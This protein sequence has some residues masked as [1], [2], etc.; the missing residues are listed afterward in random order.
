M[1]PFLLTPKSL[2]NAQLKRPEGLHRVHHSM[3]G[4]VDWAMARWSARVFRPRCR[5]ARRTQRGW[6][7][8]GFWRIMDIRLLTLYWFITILAT[9]LAVAPQRCKYTFWL[10]RGYL[11]L[12]RETTQAHGAEASR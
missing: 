11:R 4:M 1:Q 9:N 5:G 7:S 8:T 2:G 10:L 3:Y 6:S 12:E